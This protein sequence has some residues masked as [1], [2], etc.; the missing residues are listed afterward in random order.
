MDNLFTTYELFSTL[1]SYGIGA[2]GTVRGNQ[3]CGHFQEETLKENNGKL[4]E[5]GEIRTQVEY[6]E[7]GEMVLF[8]V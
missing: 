1:R 5:W 2:V 4:M 7:G 3:I 6:R 8:I